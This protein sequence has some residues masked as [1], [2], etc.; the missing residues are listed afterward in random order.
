ME[1]VRYGCRFGG[2]HLVVIEISEELPSAAKLAYE[3]K[4][5]VKA[6]NRRRAYRGESKIAYKIETSE[7]LAEQF[8][9]VAAGGFRLVE[10]RNVVQSV[11]MG[12]VFFAS[13]S[14]DGED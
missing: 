14:V 11:D 10:D 3:L 7:K 2:E 1:K 12:Q 5:V 6:E 9:D 8:P 13:D 4:N